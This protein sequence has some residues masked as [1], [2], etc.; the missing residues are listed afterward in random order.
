MNIVEV[1]NFLL[2]LVRRKRKSNGKKV[3]L[4]FDAAAGETAND[5]LL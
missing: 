5:L 4:A 3:D 1:K 2:L